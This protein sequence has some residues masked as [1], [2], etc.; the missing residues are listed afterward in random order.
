MKSSPIGWIRSPRKTQEGAPVQPRYGDESDAAEI[1]IESAFRE[2]LR[3]L[4]GFERIWVLTWLD[5]AKDYRPLVVPYRDTVERGL[6]ATRSPSRPN[7]IGLSCVELL[8]VDREAGLVSV[9]ATDLLD[10]TPVLDVKPYIPEIDAF[11]DARAGWFGDSTSNR[12][13][14]DDRFEDA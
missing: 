14:A 8:S 12:G 11:P 4:E 1:V 2:S 7:P 9:G 13:R 10:G 6:F 3:D 5:R